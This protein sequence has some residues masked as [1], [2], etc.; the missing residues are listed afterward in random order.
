VI[1]AWPP[2]L[3]GRARVLGAWFIAVPFLA[4]ASPSPRFLA[5]GG[6]LASLGLVL[7]GWSA[8]TIHKDESLATTGPYAFVRNPLYAGSLLVGLG[9]ALG[10][11]HWIWP[12]LVLGFF[13]IV[14]G[15][16][17]AEE[18]ERLTRLFGERYLEYARHVPA[19]VPRLRPYRGQ[20]DQVGSGFS[21]SRYLRNRE[22]EALLGAVAALALLLVRMRMEQ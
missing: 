21:W 1:P 10:G 9:L 13:G 15:R 5:L 19:I 3:P 14:Y 22:W 2:R 8:G 4:L 12:A 11:G 7:R 20:R 16:V 6:G 17:I 18:S